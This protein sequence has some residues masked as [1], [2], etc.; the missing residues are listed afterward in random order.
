MARKNI[1]QQDGIDELVDE[2]VSEAF[3]DGV[4]FNELYN[5]LM[6]IELFTSRDFVR[7]IGL[8]KRLLSGVAKTASAY[9]ELAKKY[10]PAMQREKELYAARLGKVRNIRRKVLRM[11]REYNGK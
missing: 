3:N 5:H 9:I 7:D 1:S 2:T 10:E 6:M 8:N 11:L 4:R